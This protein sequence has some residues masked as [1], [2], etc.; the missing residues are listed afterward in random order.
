MVEFA[1]EPRPELVEGQSAENQGF[2]SV[3]CESAWKKGQDQQRQPDS[4]CFREG[5]GRENTRFRDGK[6]M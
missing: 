3:A 2:T 6:R 5:G 4:R 1:W